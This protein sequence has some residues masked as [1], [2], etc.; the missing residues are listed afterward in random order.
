[1]HITY[2]NDFHIFPLRFTFYQWRRWGGG[3]KSPFVA[4]VT[5]YLV[6][7]IRIFYTDKAVRR[8]SP[9]SRQNPSQ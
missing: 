4:N 1:M 9:D 3:L 2:F 7:L 6:T 8:L 5:S